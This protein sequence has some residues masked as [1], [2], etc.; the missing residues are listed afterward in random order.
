MWIFIIS[1][2]IFFY[3]IRKILETLTI[4]SI[5][6]KSVLITG[7][8]SGFGRLI[9]LKCIRNNMVVFPTCM[10]DEGIKEL[11]EEGKKYGSKTYPLKM[12]VTSD[13]SC[14]KNLKYVQEVL[15]KYNINGLHG[16][17]ANAG[18][19]G[20]V[21][22]FDWMKTEDFKEV[23]E[24]N[25]FGVVRTVE[26]FKEE[27]KKAKGRIVLTAS[28]YGKVAIPSIS[29]YCAS[30]FAVEGFADSLRLEMKHF[31]VKV[32]CIEPGVFKTN[33]T[34]VDVTKKILEKVYSRVDDDLKK[35]Y[36]QEYFDNLIKGME[37]M[38]VNKSSGSPEMVAD[39]YFKSLVSY[40]PKPRYQVGFDC[41]CITA[42]LSLCPTEVQDFIIKILSY[43]SGEP[44]P[45]TSL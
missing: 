42:P 30:K 23:F 27:I 31:N 44:K 41:Q 32:I 10:T 43:L 22:P 40:W 19:T 38:F 28:L 13:E 35:Q 18:I 9:A 7:C 45:K 21:G 39:A 1:I 6:K 26:Y 20:N 24:V 33:M 29:A 14:S 5:E 8:D 16:I 4:S 36:D 12:N 34:N 15:K 2:L 3:I 11:E 37:D 25:T 17:V